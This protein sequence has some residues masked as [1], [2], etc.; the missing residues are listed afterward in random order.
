MLVSEFLDLIKNQENQPMLFEYAPGRVVQGGY[1]VTE[2]KNSTYETIDCGN[3]LHTWKEVV[4]QLWVP[5]E[6]K[7]SD[8]WMPSTK[9]MKIWDVVDSRLSLFRDAEIRIEFGDAQNLTSNYH[10]DG[11]VQTEDGLV[12]QMAPP[13]TMCKPREILIEP[14]EM[15]AAAVNESCCAPSTRKETSIPLAVAGADNSSSCC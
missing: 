1:H 6:A 7:E 14:N 15:S 12:V 5:E 2:I 9:F 11:L 3:S 13:R 8:P 4:V 10:I